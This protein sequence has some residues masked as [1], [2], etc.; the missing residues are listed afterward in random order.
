MHNKLSPPKECHRKEHG[1]R[2]LVDIAIEVGCPSIRILRGTG[3]ATT[4]LQDKFSHDPRKGGP[5][6]AELRGGLKAWIKHHKPRLL[7]TAMQAR[8][9]ELG[10]DLIYTPPYSPKFQPI[11][12]T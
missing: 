4:I 5:S 11:E 1:D 12:L 3:Q 8:F 7:Q 9:E 10:W 6:V 2:T